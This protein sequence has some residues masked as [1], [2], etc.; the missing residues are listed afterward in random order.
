MMA[1]EEEKKT[2]KKKQ[3]TTKTKTGK[4]QNLLEESEKSEMRKEEEGE[5]EPKEGKFLLG[6]PTFTQLE[7]GRFRCSETGHEMPAREVESYGRSKRCRVGLIDAFLQL[8]KAPLSSF[9]QDPLCK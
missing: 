1:E 9:Y 6:P 3:T 7:N 4:D 5:E 2:K 8:N